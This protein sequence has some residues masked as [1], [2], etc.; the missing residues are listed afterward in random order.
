MNIMQ[1]P[2]P[3]ALPTC[4]FLPVAEIGYLA[5]CNST[6]ALMTKQCILKHHTFLPS[7]IL[8]TIATFLDAP[9]ISRTIRTNLAMAK[10]TRYW[11]QGPA[12]TMLRQRD[13]LRI[14]R[15]SC[16][17]CRPD[18]AHIATAGSLLRAPPSPTSVYTTDAEADSEDEGGLL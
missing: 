1:L 3:C 7:R 15:C 10:I 18:W 6:L 17:F 16:Q 5:A 12:A 8:M 14:P 4:R 11:H 13:W 9:A 2:E